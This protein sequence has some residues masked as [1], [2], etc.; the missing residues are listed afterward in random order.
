MTS[1]WD[2][3]E[4]KM[5]GNES[6]DSDIHVRRRRYW[7]ARRRRVRVPGPENDL[8]W[9]DN[10]YGEFFIYWF[11]YQTRKG[12]SLAENHLKTM[13]TGRLIGIVSPSP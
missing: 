1:V 5:Q 13:F 12:K 11:G 7:R 8:D 10:L 3:V 6:E 4:S 2:T 9:F